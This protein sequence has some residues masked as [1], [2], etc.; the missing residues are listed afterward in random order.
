MGF[1]STEYFKEQTSQNKK[2]VRFSTSFEPIDNMSKNKTIS[3][4]PSFKRTLLSSIIAMSVMGVNAQEVTEQAK[5]ALN[6]IADV[7]DHT[8]IY[9][10]AIMGACA[11]DAT[12]NPLPDKT[13]SICK[14]SD[15][16]FL[17][18]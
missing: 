11:I 13:L 15:A 3:T 5:K 17:H 10:E 9:K 1:V 6:A 2:T 7:Y 14:K 16:I 12:G 4:V 8:F 18:I